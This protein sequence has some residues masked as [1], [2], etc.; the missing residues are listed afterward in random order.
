MLSLETG[1]AAGLPPVRLSRA[2]GSDAEV[3]LD[4]DPDRAGRQNTF[5]FNSVELE[6]PAVGDGARGLPWHLG[7]SRSDPSTSEITCSFSRARWQHS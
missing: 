4:T 3:T 7:S 6:S 1:I 2:A 5:A